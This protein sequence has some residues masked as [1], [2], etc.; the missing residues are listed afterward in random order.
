MFGGSVEWGECAPP[1]DGEAPDGAQCGEVSVP[2]DHSKPDGARATIA[3]VR[4][5]AT[6]DKIGSLLLNFGGPGYSGVDSTMHW[7]DYFPVEV[8]QHFD[9]VG[10]DPR[11]VG[12]SR[13]TV[14][15]NSDAE[16]DYDRVD[17]DV[18]NSPAGVAQDNKETEAYVRRCVEKTG[19]EVLAN[20]GTESVARDLDLLREALGD[21][22]LTYVGFSYGTQLGAKYAELF[23][24]RVRA[25]V[26]DGAVDPAAD[27]MEGIL[28]QAEGFQR[29]FEDYAADCAWRDDCPLGVDPAAAVEKFH[30]LVDPL[31]DQP[32]TTQD[33][34][35]LT[36]ND[37]LSAVTSAL[38]GPEYWDDL[39]AGLI[40]L[41]DGEPADKLLQ[42]AD[43]ASGRDEDGHYD[44][45]Y[46]AFNAINCADVEY[47]RDE[48]AWVEF[49]KRYREISPY[50][51]Y[52]EFSGHSSRGVCAFWPVPADDVPHAFSAPGLP[53]V[54]V[55]STTGDPATPYL[56]GVHLAEQM[57]AALL[58]VQG[59]KHTAFL[60][61]PC[62][63]EIAAAY[64]TD[65]VLPPADA[66]C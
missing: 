4:L 21:R 54:L 47:P 26:L 32:A 42:L 31:V 33:P 17:L 49:D 35:G 38:Y 37:A 10:F 29:A 14:E 12:R 5:P 56:D 53:R 45:S 44:N 9:I 8:Q 18:D 55:I 34:R 39:T 66:R 63:D 43:D 52:G 57:Q 40:E 41:R 59:T 61:N 20:I 48:A 36:Y 24:D 65:L 16:D 64:L 46:D 27:P 60:E 3:V 6:G 13:P 7:A 2:L 51:S 1:R 25:M 30:A 15:C 62:V 19:K 22:A 23:P 50:D 11:G 28:E 58:T